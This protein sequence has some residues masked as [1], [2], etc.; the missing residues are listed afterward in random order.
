[1][2]QKLDLLFLSDG[3]IMLY[4]EMGGK[5]H[6]PLKKKKKK[7]K[8]WFIFSKLDKK[9]GSAPI[10]SEAL[11]HDGTKVDYKVSVTAIY[12]HYM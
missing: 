1:M 2:L 10:Y 11:F 8:S 9:C 3:F 4:L 12:V 7:V 6:T 5:W